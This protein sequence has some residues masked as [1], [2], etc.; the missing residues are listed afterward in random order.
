MLIR[1]KSLFAIII[2]AEFGRV[3]VPPAALDCHVVTNVLLIG[4]G[5]ICFAAII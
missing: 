1:R 2:G 3:L 4:V 5:A